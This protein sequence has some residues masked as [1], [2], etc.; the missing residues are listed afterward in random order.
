VERAP[1]RAAV[2]CARDPYA[3]GVT[4]GDSLY[5]RTSAEWSE[6]T[7]A[8][9]RFLRD[10]AALERTTN[11]TEVNQTLV[12]RIGA[13]RFDFDLDSERAA[14]GHLLSLAVDAEYEATGL[15]ISAIVL[16]LNENDA[17]PGFFTKATELGLLAP[18]ATRDE[19]QR[20]WVDQ[21]RAVQ[22]HYRRVRHSAARVA[23]GP[24]PRRRRIGSAPALRLCSHPVLAA[25]DPFEIVVGGGVVD[26][27]FGTH[28]GHDLGADGVL[29]VAVGD[30]EDLLHNLRR[31][32]HGPTVA[33]LQAMEGGEDLRSAGRLSS[34]PA[35]S[36]L[37]V[38]C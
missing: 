21:V 11:Y 17:G 3:A 37:D 22:D 19:H 6:L 8:T 9:V 18:N 28:P 24:E 10:R 34:R 7:A 23:S 20:F 30:S 36:L 4:D 38:A 16:Y 29:R 1:A 25:S 2:A 33:S 27:R 32:E 14:M 15:M 31:C 35:A 13:R 26:G 5:G 12:R